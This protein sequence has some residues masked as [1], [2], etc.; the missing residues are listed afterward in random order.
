MARSRSRADGVYIALLRA[1]NV[2]GNNKLPMSDLAAMFSEAGCHDVR[3]YIQSGNVV[4]AAS[5]GC[6]KS[7]AGKIERAITERFGFRAPVVLRTAAEM[8]RVLSANPFLESDPTSLHVGF[9]NKAPGKRQAAGLDPQRSPGDSFALVGNEIY[10]CLQN[11]VGKTKLTTA[12]LESKLDAIV[13][14][15]NWRTVQKLSALCGGS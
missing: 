9:L 6:A 2:G 5:A 3:T 4:F 11:G 14:I 7:L 1:V 12:Y 10:L 8:Q 13:T 15:R